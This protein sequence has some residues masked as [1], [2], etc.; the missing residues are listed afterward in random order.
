VGACMS[1]LVEERKTHICID[2]E[3]EAE[4]ERE[5][6]TGRQADRTPNSMVR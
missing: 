3:T 4:R 5:R 6:E 1:V 2:R